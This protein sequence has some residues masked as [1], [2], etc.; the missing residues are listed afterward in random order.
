MTGSISPPPTKRRKVRAECGNLTDFG[1]TLETST[2]TAASDPSDQPVHIISWNINGITPFVRHHLTKPITNYFSKSPKSVRIPSSQSGLSQPPSLRAFLCRHNYPHLLFLQEV[3]INSKDEATQRAVQAAINTPESSETAQLPPTY[4]AH[5]TLPCDPHN[6]RGFGGR[7]YGVVSII[8]DDFADRC[9][10]AVRTVD[11]D[12]EGR[13]SIVEITSPQPRH[14]IPS[15]LPPSAKPSAPRPAS[16]HDDKPSTAHPSNIAVFNIYAVNGTNN[17]YK[18]PKTGTTCGTRHDRKLA[19]HKLLME[20]SLRYE[21]R[22]WAVILGGDMNVAP[23]R[24]DG[25]P[26]LRTYPREH[27]V[28]RADFNTRFLLGEDMKALGGNEDGEHVFQGI[29]IW[30]TL[31][32]PEASGYTYYP[33]GTAWGASCDRVDYFVISKG[34]YEEGKVVEAEI[35][36]NALERGPSDHVPISMVLSLR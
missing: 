3:K 36:A 15:P 12:V 5:F 29:D 8:R 32:G 23:A 2:T 26:N 25:Y 18:D 1:A 33:R 4:T 13:V 20:E 27:I 30:R 11:W 9:V 31:H 16:S 6:A 14:P 19:F 7:I 35:H 10:S 24:I 34:L 17:A 28:N 21:A 22:G